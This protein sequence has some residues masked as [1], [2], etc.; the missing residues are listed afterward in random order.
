VS[1]HNDPSPSVLG[2]TLEAE[3]DQE[4]LDAA[5]RFLSHRPRSERE[6][7]R[8]LSEKGH[9]AE[10]IDRVVARLAELKLIDDR[11]FAGYWLENRALH[12]PRGGRALRAELYQKGLDREVV[13]EAL[14]VERDEP[15]DAY[16]AALRRAATLSTLDE[17]DF[18]QR[19]S[20]FLLRRGFDWETVNPT[21]DR[22]W[23]EHADERMIPPG[24]A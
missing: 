24:T 17:A 4:C 22:L 20:Q 3:R 16:R 1:P 6:V 9:E 14:S 10:R 8:R 12:K 2:K 7:R 19:L 11:D 13:D 15:D 5:L 18:R 23:R 21:V